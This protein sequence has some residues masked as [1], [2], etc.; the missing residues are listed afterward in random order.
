MPIPSLGHEVC[1]RDTLVKKGE[2]AE[3][4]DKVLHRPQSSS[5]FI[6]APKQTAPEVLPDAPALSHFWK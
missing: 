1:I 2:E 4:G 3:S 6:T 5:Q